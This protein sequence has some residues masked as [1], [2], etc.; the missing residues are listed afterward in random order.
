MMSQSDQKAVLMDDNFG[1]L[2]AGTLALLLLMVILDHGW[3][4]FPGP[5]PDV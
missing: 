4:G 3:R 1:G 2:L 5:G